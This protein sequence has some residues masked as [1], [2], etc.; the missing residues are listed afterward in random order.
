MLE[1][2]YALKYSMPHSVVHIIDNSMYTGELPTVVAD[3]PSLYSTLVVSGAPMGAD[4]EI[5]SIN[6]SDVLNVAYGMSNLSPADIKKYGQT[7][8]YPSSILSQNA[9]IKFMRVTPPDSTYAFS[10]LLIQWKWDG[11]TMHVR[12]KTTSGNGNNGLPP[13]VIHSSFKNTERL[14]NILVN[15]FKQDNVP[16][17]S[18]GSKWTQ[19]VFMTAIA[20]GRGKVYNFFNYSINLTQQTRRPANVRYLFSTMDTRVSQVVEQFAASLVNENNS[21]RLDAI[22]SVN[23]AVGKRVKGSSILIPTINESAI[24][25]LY[26]EYMQHMKEMIDAQIPPVYGTRDMQF[27]SDVYKT[28]NVNIFE[29]IY[30][31]YIYNGDTDVKLPYYQ[32]DMV[33]LEIPRLPEANRIKTYLDGDATEYSTNPTD[34]QSIL[35]AKSYGIENGAD[36]YHV[37]DVF[38]NAPTSLSIQVITGINQY[39]GAVTSIPI[40]QIWKSNDH[41]DVNNKDMIR[42]YVSSINDST[43]ITNAINTLLTTRK[44]IP[45]S[46]IDETDATKYVY[47]PD[48]VIVGLTDALNTGNKL[49]SFAIYKVEYAKQSITSNKAP[50]IQNTTPTE[51]NDIYKMLVYPDTQVTSFAIKTGVPATDTSPYLTT[52]GSTVINTADGTVYVTGYN[53]A[54]DA[55]DKLTVQSQNKFSIG[56][57]PTKVAVSTD[58][59]GASYD[60]MIYMEYGSVTLTWKIV[61]GTFAADSQTPVTKYVLGDLVKLGTGVGGHTV[62]VDTYFKVTKVTLVDPTNPSTSRQVLEVA[63]AVGG[64]IE[65]TQIHPDKYAT[66]DTYRKL[67][68][69]PA[70]FNPRSYLKLANGALDPGEDGDTFAG[71]EWYQAI[72]DITP[73]VDPGTGL[74]IIIDAQN[75]N[76]TTKPADAAPAYIYRYTVGG[77][78]GSLYRYGLA[79][80]DIPSN[81]YAQNYGINPNSE[82]GGIP[83][84][85]G[86]AGF[87][88]DAISD[89][90]F[91]WRYSELL[92]RAYRGEIDPRIS[93]PTRCPAKYLFDGGT[94]TIVGQTILPYIKYKPV[95]IINASTIYTDD[96]KEAILLDETLI[97]SITEFADV[98]V[99]QAMYDLMILRVYQGMPEDMRPLGPGSGLSLHLDAGVTDANTAMLVNQSFTKRFDNPNA[100]WDI[101]GFVSSADGISYTYIKQ[102]VDN[103]FSHMRQYSVNKPYT[104]KYSNIAPTEYTGFFPDIDT[105]DWELRQLLYTSGG[106]AWIMD[107]NGNLQR[108]SQRTLDREATGTS[109]LI[110]ESNMRTLSQLVYLLQNKINSYLLEYNDD[111]VLQTLKDEVDNMFSNWVGNLVQDLDIYFKRDINPEDGGE[112][113]VCYVSVTFRGL[114]LRVPIIVN[115]QRRTTSE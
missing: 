40:S 111:G 36:T 110:Q 81:Y 94:N 107:I 68:E 37:G 35:V 9:P 67:T 21:T 18:D 49:M 24:K 19:R 89:I 1:S 113:V 70:E 97:S 83:V 53:I 32:V 15:K 5:I 47:T 3:D 99:K 93:S 26:N 11:N 98:D 30:G 27:V 33:D 12:F 103:L 50:T 43:A 87:F 78:M 84:E 39:T 38:C 73:A 45:R 75:I 16:D 102:I 108:Q 72:S 82:T 25:E 7:V 10:C 56:S 88:D 46:K 6:R 54:T 23:V 51:G 42:G 80:V 2:R 63:P 60:D 74:V 101:G 115:V 92:V 86:Y 91:K 57:V 64:V 4:N 109:D 8:T 76:V 17:D 14:N 34:I 104:G 28:M 95:D 29:A 58:I 66:T 114:I 22:D 41:T 48:Y 69:E 59:I 100:S 44:L 31:R 61:G 79:N 85:Y 112:I 52:P 13:G 71:N 77:T 105:T 62:P 96:E 20:A 65:G 106:N 55:N 90:E